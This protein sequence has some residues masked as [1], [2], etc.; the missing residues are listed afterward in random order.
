MGKILKG[1]NV[2]VITG[3]NKGQRGTVKQVN[4]KQ[5]TV[6]VE[7]VQLV[8]RHVKQTQTQEGGIVRKESP[9]HISNVALYDE[10]TSKAGKVGYKVLEDG[11]KVRYFK[12]DNRLIET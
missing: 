12:S 1:D 11:K 10:K 3:K 7:G 9:I 2:I 5:N 8:A 4:A 6:V